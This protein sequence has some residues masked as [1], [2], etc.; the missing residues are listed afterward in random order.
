MNNYYKKTICR[1]SLR[2]LLII[3]IG[4]SNFTNAMEEAAYQRPYGSFSRIS[5]RV[6]PGPGSI[7]D[8]YQYG[9]RF[10][11][12]SLSTQGPIVGS[13]AL[14]LSF[15]NQR[16]TEGI[17]ITDPY[18]TAPKS[19]IATCSESPASTDSLASSA[20]F[21]SPLSKKQ[22]SESELSVSGSW[23]STLPSES[24]GRA[25]R[26]SSLSSSDCVP[27]EEVDLTSP[28][29]PG[30]ESEVGKKSQSDNTSE[31]LKVLEKNRQGLVSWLS[32]PPAPEKSSEDSQQHMIQGCGTAARLFAGMSPQE[33]LA[34]VSKD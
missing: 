28:T 7:E 9:S 26:S 12:G 31:M 8:S 19:S 33:L 17:V 34:Y 13:Q 23:S 15:A 18:Y 3:G 25:E 11:Q 5:K 22:G 30:S 29:V 21:E 4:A 6:V 20:T 1:K 14:K 2:T 16:R 32:S 24:L 10:Y 27:V